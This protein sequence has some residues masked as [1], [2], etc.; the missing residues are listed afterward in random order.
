MTEP[1][2]AVVEGSEGIQTPTL[3]GGTVSL[4]VDAPPP[5]AAS[6]TV[7]NISVTDIHIVD[8]FV[9]PGRWFFEGFIVISIANCVRYVAITRQT[10]A[11]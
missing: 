10:G 9:P 1:H 6:A 5:Q 4:V 7:M 2:S 3:G 8:F 11:G